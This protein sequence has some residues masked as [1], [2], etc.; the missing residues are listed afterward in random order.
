MFLSSSDHPELVFT[1]NKLV[2]KTQMNYFVNNYWIIR[3]NLILIFVKLLVL[4]FKLFIKARLWILKK[5]LCLLVVTGFGQ[6]SSR[7]FKNIVYIGLLVVDFD[8][9]I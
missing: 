3:E 9:K 2:Y 8:R 7:A 4:T 1:S 5:N 6:N